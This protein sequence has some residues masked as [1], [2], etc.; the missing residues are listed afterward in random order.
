MT[1]HHHPARR[2]LG[3]IAVILLALLPAQQA[4][5]QTRD[6]ASAKTRMGYDAAKSVAMTGLTVARVDT[7]TQGDRPS[8]SALLTSGTD[9]VHATIAPV[10]FLVQKAM[11]LNAGD[12]VDIT[13]S[14]SMMGSSAMLIASELKK[15]AVTLTLRDKATG[16]P[17]WDRP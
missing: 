10:D 8:V 12:V 16:Q 4:Q 13:G 15:G 3:T 7:T 6:S 5:A 9:S 14:K 17:A 1:T 11:T 2:T